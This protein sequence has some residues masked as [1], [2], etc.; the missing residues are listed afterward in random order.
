MIKKPIIKKVTPK[1]L[2]LF[3]FVFLINSSILFIL[4][5]KMVINKPSIKKSNPIAVIRSFI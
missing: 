5:G 2:S 3:S 4:D 1:P